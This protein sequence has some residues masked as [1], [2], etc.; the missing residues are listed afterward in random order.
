MVDA[1]NP[2]DPESGSSSTTTMVEGASLRLKRWISAE[3]SVQPAAPHRG[4]AVVAGSAGGRARDAPPPLSDR[5]AAAL[6]G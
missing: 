4:A 2:A 1:A 3:T 6:G 5:S